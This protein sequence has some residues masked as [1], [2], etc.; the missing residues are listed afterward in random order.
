MYLL[1]R[2]AAALVAASALT[3]GA[4]GSEAPTATENPGTDGAVFDNPRIFSLNPATVTFTRQPGDPLPTGPQW[5]LVQGIIAAAT[6][7]QFGPITWG[8]GASNWFDRSTAAN[9]SNL[10][11]LGWNFSFNLNQNAVPLPEGLYEAWIPVTVPA[12]LNNPQMLRVVYDYCNNCIFLGSDRDAELTPADPT[13]ARSSTYNNTGTYP[14]DDWRLFV[15]PGQTV[16]VELIGG[17][18][19]ASYTHPDNYIYVFTTAFAFV[20]SDDDGGCVHDSY[21]EVT[22]PGATR[23]E[24]LVRATSFSDTQF[25]T[26]HVRVTAAGGGGALRVAD[27]GDKATIEGR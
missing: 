11:A 22:N 15:D 7:P 10:P 21:I 12:A 17:D 8:D 23:M 26:Y 16:A 4:C 13:W 18:C 6:F 20:G 2:Y 14:Y 25:G 1:R 19:D 3:L 9:F 24:F 27:E 5:S